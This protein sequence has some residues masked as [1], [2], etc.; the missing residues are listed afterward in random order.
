MKC[1]K[2]LFDKRLIYD[3]WSKFVSTEKSK[4]L[5]GNNLR[6]EEHKN[7]V[8]FGCGLGFI[9]DDFVGARYI[10]IDPLPTL[11]L[12]AQ[13]RLKY[14]LN[15]EFI[16][17]DQNSLKSLPSNEFDLLFGVGVLHHMSDSQIEVL[18]SELKRI[19]TRN[20][21]VFFWEPNLDESTRRLERFFIKLDRGQIARSASQY[22]KLLGQ[23]NFNFSTQVHRNV[24]RIPYDVIIIEGLVKPS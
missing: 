8:D 15:V 17:G 11:V 7:V 18:N 20:G 5:L 14:K 19:L 9:A 23:D 21:R 16:V 2:V 22:L 6:L 3:L 12:Q 4:V 1:V 24:L 10:G 13:K